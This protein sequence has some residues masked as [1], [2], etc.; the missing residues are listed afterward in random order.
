MK[1]KALL[2]LATI[3]LSGSALSPSY[4]QSFWDNNQGGDFHFP[5]NWIPVPPGP[6]DEA[7]FQI[8]GTA[9]TISFNT[10]ANS[11]SVTVRDGE[12]TFDLFN[13]GT[14]TQVYEVLGDVTIEMP[15]GDASTTSLT[16][17]E[18]SV[19]ASGFIQV[20]GGATLNGTGQ[21]MGLELNVSSN[22]TLGGTL[23]FN[24][25]GNLTNNG[26]VKPGNSG[27]IGTLNANSNYAQNAGGTLEIEI[28]GSMPVAESDI[29]QHSGGGIVTLSGQLRVPFLGGYMP[30]PNDNF[31]FLTSQLPSGG[32]IGQ[33]H[34]L[35]LP[36]LTGNV[37]A[38]VDYTASTASIQFLTASTRQFFPGA[39]SPSGPN[40]WSNPTFWGGSQVPDSTNV[41]NL[42]NNTPNDLTLELRNDPAD[43]V[44]TDAFT[45]F[46]TLSG[47]NQTMTLRVPEGT[48]FTAVQQMNVNNN[49]ILHL[50]GGT[51]H[52]NRLKINPGG[53]LNGDGGTI[54]GT[55]Q[56][57]TNQPSSAVAIFSTGN[58]PGTTTIE[59]NLDVNTNGQL[60]IDV[61]D[62]NSFD[63]VEVT[64]TANLAGTLNVVAGSISPLPTDGVTEVT[65][66]TAT[67]GVVSRFDNVVTSGMQDHFFA[68]RYDSGSVSLLSYLEGDMNRNGLRNAEDVTFFAM[69]VTDP[70]GYFD[71]FFIFGEQSG[72]INDDGLFDF[73]DI[74]PFS[75][76]S[77]IGLTA[78]EIVA[79]IEAYQHAVPEPST[80]LGFCILG[81]IFALG[82][83][84]LRNRC[85]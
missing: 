27:S 28:D 20:V 80:I 82:R 83:N 35:S 4:G 23:T 5:G 31:T 56:V 46:T 15:M 51:V 69:A 81:G 66:L 39:L 32:I 22:S 58:S 19:N 77:G 65:I 49:G 18:G 26:F 40:F 63:M 74:G 29:L 17:N 54:N 47:T 3:C 36:N 2:L 84:C 42:I 25:N 16:V 45:H 12:V 85:S 61:V 72:D 70:D 30:Q 11:G 79:A 41:V 7:I 38:R 57:G 76:L 68:P 53:L 37:A 10:T 50:D 48:N 33:F 43:P 1:S 62:M 64:Q 60:D 71:Q 75:Q 14:G 78:E 73:D 9:Y 6:M 59:G 21:L 67:N 8:P 24:S 44:S 55:L 34:S 13:A 52:T